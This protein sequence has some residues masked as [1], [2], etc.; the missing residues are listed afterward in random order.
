MLT[1]PLAVR[2]EPFERSAQRRTLGWHLSPRLCNRSVKQA[3]G[4]AS[5]CRPKMAALKPGRGNPS[6]RKGSPKG[7]LMSMVLVVDHERR[8]CA[9][10]PP[11]RARHLLTRG[12][13]AV[14]RRFPALNV[15]LDHADAVM[16][17]FAAS[18]EYAP[19]DPVT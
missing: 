8:P 9:P 12:R 4:E 11:G 1:S 3:H 14:Y 2:Q 6:P 19:P 17:A 7:W 5:Q 13:A 18:L 15:R 16:L 10:I